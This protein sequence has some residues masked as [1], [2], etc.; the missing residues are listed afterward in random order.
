MRIN[1]FRNRQSVAPLP[2]GIPLTANRLPLEGNVLNERET[3]AHVAVTEERINARQREI[4]NNINTFGSLYTPNIPSGMLQMLTENYRTVNPHLRGE[5]PFRISYSI[6]SQY[7]QARAANRRY[8]EQNDADRNRIG[9]IGGKLV[10]VA[11]QVETPMDL[12]VPPVPLDYPLAQ[13]IP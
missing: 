4:D 7:D 2:A 8:G 5:D 3:A 11:R 9:L 6:S 10:P 13:N 12:D 1:P